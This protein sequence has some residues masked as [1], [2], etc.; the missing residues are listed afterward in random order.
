MPH[1]E[2]FEGRSLLACTVTL[3]PA[4]V[5]TV[6]GDAGANT[7]MVNTVVT[8][9]VAKVTVTCDGVMTTPAA[10]VT[11][12]VIDT[13]AGNDRVAFALTAQLT[14]L[15][16]AGPLGSVVVNLGP[17]NDAFNGDIHDAAFA[18][19]SFGLSVAGN[20]GNDALQ[21]ALARLVVGFVGAPH[22]Q[23]SGDD[24]NDTLGV[25]ATDISLPTR[26][27][28][29]AL[30]L[31]GG[32]G[33]DR[34]AV[35]Y[36]GTVRGALR[37]TADGGKGKDQVRVDISLSRDSLLDANL[38]GSL[39]ARVLG[40]ADN[41]RLALFVHPRS[42]RRGQIDALIDGATGYDPARATGNVRRRGGES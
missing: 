33:S 21:L 29:I 14:S 2:T 6:V 38:G 41:D 30:G 12:L 20:S 25:N 23:L 9:G 16:S 37:V 5:L 1:L 8:G 24:G 4:G 26:W 32:R 27:G 17:G 15:P 7:V 36:Q 11:S 19:S 3:N 28:G 40:G 18:M 34:I 35:T 42:V 13:A 10:T 31:F 39:K 22:I